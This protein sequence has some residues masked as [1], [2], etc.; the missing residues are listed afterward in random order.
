MRWRWA[1]T[2]SAIGHPDPANR[3]STAQALADAQRLRERL[4]AA[5]AS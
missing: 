2:S 5:N 3:P 4:I 1:C